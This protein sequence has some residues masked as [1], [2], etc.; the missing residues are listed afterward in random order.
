MFHTTLLMLAC[1]AAVRERSEAWERHILDSLALLA[2]IDKHMPSSVNHSM[3]VIDVGTG[4]GL[5]GMVL[6][7]A[8]PQWRVGWA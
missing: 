5:P 3:L 4:A 2:V 1:T 8:R 7:V 6:A